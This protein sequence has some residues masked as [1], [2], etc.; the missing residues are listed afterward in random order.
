MTKTP[1]SQDSIGEPLLSERQIDRI[2][3]AV[4]DRFEEQ[5][6]F[7]QQLVRADSLRGNEAGVQGIVSDALGVASDYEMCGI[8]AIDPTT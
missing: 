1:F 7:L 5:V 2:I 4:E 6:A 8:L 3:R